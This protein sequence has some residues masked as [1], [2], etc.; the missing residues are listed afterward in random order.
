MIRSSRRL[1]RRAL[2]RNAALGGSGLLAAYLLGCGDGE[3][4]RPASTATAPATSPAAPATTAPS[5]TA[6][7]ALR[8][9]PLSPA[10]VLPPPRRDHSL[11]SDGRRLFLFGGRQQQELGDLW[12]YDLAAATWTEITA[13]GAPPARFGHNAFL[14]EARSRMVVFGGQAGG[15]FFNDLWAFDLTNGGWSQLTAGQGAPLARYGAGG[16]LDAA[17]RL[18]VSHGF[19]T[20]GRFDDTWEYSLEDASWTD[21]SPPAGGR[22]IERCLMRAVWDRQAGRLLIFGGQTNATPFLG[23]L[24]ELRQGAWQELTAD[25]RPSPR[26]LYAMAYDDEAGRALLFGGNSQTGPLGDLWFFDSALNTWSK[27]SPPGE[28]PSPRFGHDAVWLP[29]SRALVVFGGNDNSQDLNDL[30]E[31]A[32]PL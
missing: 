13:A 16:A 30:W 14:D 12:T 19:T 17:G 22:P 9:R 8:W 15:A 27:P 3:T 28:A 11:V 10:G 31:L 29:A 25:P 2:I 32:A 1:S 7:A 4:A 20:S 23:D 21:V 24:W 6:P 26:N 5:A 18:L